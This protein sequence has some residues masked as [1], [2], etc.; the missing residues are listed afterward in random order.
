MV[1]TTLIIIRICNWK[2]PQ[3]TFIIQFGKLFRIGNRR[4][5]GEYDDRIHSRQRRK[6]GRKN[7][8]KTIWKKET[9]MKPL[10]F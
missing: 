5:R 7:V 9:K 6:K 3:P 1:S 2:N 10:L 8:S 4:G